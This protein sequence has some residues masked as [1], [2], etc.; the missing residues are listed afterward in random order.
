MTTLAALAFACLAV[1]L[2]PEECL[3]VAWVESRCTPGLVNAQSGAAGLMQVRGGRTGSVVVEA[4]DGARALA[5]WH[6]HR[7]RHPWRGYACGWRD[8]SPRCAAYERAVRNVLR[9]LRAP[10]E[11]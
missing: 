7:P 2:E 8:G 4:W 10:G 6:K 3:A 11:V 9:R 1:G 5:Y